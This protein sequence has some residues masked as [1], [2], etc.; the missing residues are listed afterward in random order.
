MFCSKKL[1]KFKN[2]KHYFFSRNNGFSKGLYKSLNCGRGSGDKKM[3]IKKNLKYIAKKMNINYQNLILMH[4]THS[5]KVIEI[6]SGR[7]KIYGDAMITKNKKFALGVVTA[8]CVPILLFDKRNKVIGCIHAGWKGAFNG[9]IEK[10]IKNIKKIGTENEIFASVGPCIGKY[11]YE[12]DI[13]FYKMFLEK[14]KKN[15]NYFLN[16][17]KTK[18][19]F[20][21]RKFVHNKLLNL[22]VKVDHINRDTYKEKKNFFSFRRSL[23]LKQ[24]DYGRCISVISMI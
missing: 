12:V 4:Q 7:K 19:Y 15:R 13:S 23:K 6:K 11:S 24:N 14:S 8:D 21:L 16:K 20:D 17:N 22:K 18:K 3:N 2:I 10:T 1:K 9:I 5:N